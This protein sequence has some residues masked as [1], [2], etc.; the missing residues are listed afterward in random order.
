MCVHPC[1]VY[2]AQEPLLF[3]AGLCIVETAIIL[4]S[5]GF[6]LSLHIALCLSPPV[7]SSFILSPFSLYAFDALSLFFSSA[8]SFHC[9]SLAVVRCFMGCLLKRRGI[10]ASRFYPPF[11]LFCLPQSKRN[12]LSAAFS[13]LAALLLHD[14]EAMAARRMHVCAHRQ[15]DSTERL[16]APFLCYFSFLHPKTADRLFTHSST[17]TYL[18]AQFHRMSHFF[19]FCPHRQTHT[20]TH[21]GGGGLLCLN[22][23]LVSPPLSCDWTVNVAAGERNGG[24]SRPTASKFT[25]HFLHTCREQSSR[26]PTQ[27]HANTCRHTRQEICRKYVC[28]EAY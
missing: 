27:T 11:P 28:F 7:V 5:F 4:L 19:F 10:V 21:Q 22:T 24:R 2:K 18:K 17:C 1:S 15:T 8:L 13:F 26:A 20:Y 16:I 12:R 25:F 6:L 3:P 23:E 9:C 14:L